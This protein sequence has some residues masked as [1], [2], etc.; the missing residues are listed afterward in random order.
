MDWARAR[1]PVFILSDTFYE[2]AG[3]LLKKLGYPTLLCHSIADD[4]KA[5]CL[6]YTLRQENQKQ[7]AV[8][9]LRSLNYKVAAAG[10]SYNDIH[11]LKAANTG[12]F[13]KAPASI[14]GEF[15]QFP[16]LHEYAELKAFLIKSL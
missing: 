3:P 9:A 8:E 1:C 10:D 11:M 14:A 15:P 7:K 5:K 4:E 2:F 13:F 16:S 6:R 12:A